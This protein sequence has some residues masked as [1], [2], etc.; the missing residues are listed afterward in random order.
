MIQQHVTA[1][2]DLGK[3]SKNVETLKKKINGPELMAVVKANAYGH[4]LVQSANAA[5]RG[6]A[7]WLATAL[8]EEAIELR[9]SG[10]SGRIL[11]WL[12]TNQDRFA[13]CIDKDIDLGVNSLESLAGIAAAAREINKSARVHIKIDTGLGRNGV[14][15]T[16]LPDLISA[17][18]K[19][20]NSGLVNVVGAMSHFAYAD[21]PN[22]S[23]INEQVQNFK[24][25]VDALA[26]ANFDL[27]VRHLSNSA[28]TLGLPD[29]YFN[30]VRPGVAIYGISPGP[31]VGEAFDHDLKPVMRLFAP[32]VLIKEVPA[33]TGVS[34]AHQYHTTSATKLALIP[35][36]YADGIPRSASNKGPVLINDKRFTVSGRVCM[37]QFVVDIGDLDAKVGDLAILFGDPANAEPSVNEWATAAGTINYEIVTRLGPRVH[38]NY[39]N[40]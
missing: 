34:Y 29:T 9:D 25:A 19:A 21:E 28:A 24:I 36:G 16:D 7:D 10:V 40:G 37:D 2:I 22:N 38:R 18:K 30:L 15:L 3:L 33:G 8:L 1:E 12:N 26:D 32:I 14:T 11:T 20:Q 5:K 23:T 13:Q 27:E 39:L 35:T 4:G 6:G 31:E 17:L